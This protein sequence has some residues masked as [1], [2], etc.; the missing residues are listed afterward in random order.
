M[1]RDE[2]LEENSNK[3]GIVIEA[4]LFGLVRVHQQGPDLA[5]EFGVWP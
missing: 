3:H 2:G 5:L 1:V 4:E